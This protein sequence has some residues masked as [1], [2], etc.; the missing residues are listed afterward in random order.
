MASKNMGD[1]SAG[2]GPITNS[3]SYKNSLF[4]SSECYSNQIWTYID[5]EYTDQPIIIA[6]C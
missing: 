1:F 5:M 4:S 3:R 6:N 2:K